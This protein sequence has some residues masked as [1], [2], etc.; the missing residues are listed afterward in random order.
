M[1]VYAIADTHLSL[2]TQ[3]PMDVFKGWH[4]YVQRL[5]QNWK[6]TVSEGDTVVIA[7]DVSWGMDMSGSLADF[8]FLESLPGRKLLM[9]G[10]HDYWWTTVRKMESF[11]EEHGLLSFGFL[12]NNSVFINGINLCGTR[13]WMFEKG[14]T[15]DEKMINRE[16]SRLETSLSSAGSEGEKVVFM[17]YPPIFDKQM[18]G[19]FFD[20]MLSHGVK[21]CYYGHLH[22]DAARFA[23]EGEY[24]GILFRLISCDHTGF[25][26]VK[27]SD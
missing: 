21:R 15:H 10:N 1:A 26:P 4:G 7:G 6:D 20:I 27:I 19:K 12:H 23:F 22:A 17:H 8:Q 9:K 2:G 3:K 25:C 13:G 16:A 5:E 14:E 18:T 11:F 24:C